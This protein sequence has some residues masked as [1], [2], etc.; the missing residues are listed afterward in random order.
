ML[1]LVTGLM[2]TGTS[3]ISKFLH[4]M[5]IPMGTQMRFPLL[6]SRAHLEWEDTVLT[7]TLLKSIIKQEDPSDFIREYIGSREAGNWGVKSPF[8]LP[9]LDIFIEIAE[10]LDEEH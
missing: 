2:R 7:D 3:P 9:Y 5:G 6:N 1:T 10:S 8:L 4:E